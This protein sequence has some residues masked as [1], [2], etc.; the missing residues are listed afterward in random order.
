LSSASACAHR[1]GNFSGQ[2]HPGFFLPGF[3]DFIFAVPFVFIGQEAGVAALN[4]KLTNNKT[5]AK[6]I[7]SGIQCGG[8][9]MVLN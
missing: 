8:A 7:S 5:R 4:I 6:K 2:S 3:F 1:H 9:D